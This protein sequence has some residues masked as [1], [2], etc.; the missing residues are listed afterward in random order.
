MS[1]A[2]SWFRL[3]FVYKP[4]ADRR[5]SPALVAVHWDCH[6]PRQ[7]SV[8]NLSNSGAYLHTSERWLPGEIIAL[9]LQ[10]KGNLEPSPRSRFTLQA[11]AVRRDQNGVGVSFLLPKGTEP[12]LWESTI[13]SNAPQTEPEDVV[14]EFRTAAAIAFIN[15]I[16]SASIDRVTWLLRRGLSS[17]RLENAVEVALHAEELLALNPAHRRA[18]VH[19]D[20]V[21]RI[22]EDGS[23]PD[24]EWI[25]HYWSGLLVSSC[26][27]SDSHT[28]DL[29][30]PELLSQLTTIQAR[31]LAAACDS[32]SKYV[33]SYGH[34][35]AKR[36]ARSAD[37]LIRISGTHDLAHIDRDVQHLSWLG[38]LEQTVKWKFF[39]ALEE[40]N[41]TPTPLGLKLY[42]RCHAH[43][44]DLAQFYGLET[45][46]APSYSAD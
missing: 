32:A 3:P 41:I 36:L 44:A 9:T 18:S 2:R 11:K 21:L 27:Q 6:N 19:P 13:Q 35:R 25:Q 42:A 24:S 37:E 8:V 16:S 33:D 43:R 26:T 1:S 17:H 20:V 30:A 12:R 34:I 7:N 29:E 4:R 38:L 15:R 45:A 23:W 5:E 10:R 31:I 39:A 40:A 22:L 46:M 14:R 28:P